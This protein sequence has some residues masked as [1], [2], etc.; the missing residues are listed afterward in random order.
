MLH[1]GHYLYGKELS[2]LGTVIVTADVHIDPVNPKDESQ[3]TSH[4]SVHM[5]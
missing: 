2:Y 5:E 4:M 1:A 3:N